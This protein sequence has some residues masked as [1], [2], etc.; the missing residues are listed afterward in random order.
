MAG[1]KAL[2]RGLGALLPGADRPSGHESPVLLPLEDIRPNPVQPRK[3]LDPERLESL[4]ESVK[5][6]GIIQPLVVRPAGGGYEI[7]A[8]ERRWRAAKLAGL[9]EVPVRLLVLNESQS[10][11]AALVENLQREDLSPL[12]VADGIRD[13]ISRFALSHEEA[14]RRL[15]FS[16]AAV[17]NKLRLLA[18]PDSVKALLVSGSLSEGHARAIL[19]L[20]D[21]A[22]IRKIAEKVVRED[23]SVRQVESLVRHE[24][25]R[26]AERPAEARKTVP[27]PAGIRDYFTA[28]GFR[29]ALSRKNG[30]LALTLEG[31]T[32]SQANRLLEMIRTG[33][34]EV[35]LREEA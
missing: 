21:P 10:I 35:F 9:K 30:S 22:K 14:A 24:K 18:L 1:Q 8:G 2:G 19:A 32:E 27:V 28:K 7:V 15:G 23:L 4:A 31:L 34:D 16:R 20:E 26:P 17:T 12:E 25:E 3:T 13:L 11:Q 6:H 5:T 29:V 33:G